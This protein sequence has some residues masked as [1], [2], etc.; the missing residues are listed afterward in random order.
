LIITAEHDIE[1]CREVADLL[2]QKVVGSKKIDIPGAGHVMNMEKPEEF[3][4]A[5]LEFLDATA[6]EQDDNRED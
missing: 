6:A 1:A 3:N 5:V 4:R 2:Q